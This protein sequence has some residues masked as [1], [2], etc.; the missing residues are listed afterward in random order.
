MS[1]RL[2]HAPEEATCGGDNG[3]R[4][5]RPGS[6]DLG[7]LD[8]FTGRSPGACTGRLSRTASGCR[9][10]HSR[11][12]IDAGWRGEARQSAHH[13]IL[14]QIGRM[15][16]ARVGAPSR[17]NSRPDRKKGRPRLLVLVPIRCRSPGENGSG[18]DAYSAGLPSIAF[19]R[20]SY[21]SQS[22][23]TLATLISSALA[24]SSLPFSA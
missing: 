1:G 2:P 15:S 23:Q 21:C 19:S 3:P 24:R 16:P 13:R 17:P 7:G 9:Q 22:V 12:S 5:R 6:D 4:S 10:N 14:Q 20:S 18:A 8:C 11:S